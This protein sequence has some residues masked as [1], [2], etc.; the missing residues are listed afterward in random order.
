MRNL[1]TRWA[2]LEPGR[3]KR[4]TRPNWDWHEEFE[5]FY[6][7]GEAG[8]KDEPGHCWGWTLV[9]TDSEPRGF[10]PWESEALMRIGYAVQEATQA[11]GWRYSLEYFPITKLYEVKVLHTQGRGSSPTEAILA[12]YLQVLEGER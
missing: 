8:N 3:C 10:W 2:E 12:A 7:A 9:L 11:R 1:L 4:E 6:I 5:D